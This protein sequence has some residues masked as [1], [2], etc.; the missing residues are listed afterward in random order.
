[1]Q[2]RCLR[3]S[4]GSRDVEVVDILRSI[5]RGVLGGS[6][7]GLGSLWVWAPSAQDAGAYIF[8]RISQGK[9][10]GLRIEAL[11]NIMRP[12]PRGGV[13]ATGSGR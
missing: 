7:I 11:S 13:T 12:G 8:R 4:R 6:Q 1:M 9:G 5:G 2:K 10:F 3:C